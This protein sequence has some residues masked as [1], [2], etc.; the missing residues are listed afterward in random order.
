MSESRIEK[1][2][3]I[4]KRLLKEK[5]KEKAKKLIKIFLYIF[6]PIFTILLIIYFFIRVVGNM[7]LVVREYDVYKENLPKDFEGVKIVQFSDLHFNNNSSI[8][9][10][11]KMKELINK[12]NPDIVIFTG[13]L[14]DH[15]YSI[16]SDTLELLM[17]ELNG[18]N[19][20]YGKYAIKGEEDS[21]NFNIVFNNSNFKI[22][23]NSIERIYSG[24]SFIDLLAVDET[25][26]KENIKGYNDND[27]IISIIH[28]PDLAD[29]I[30]GD[31]NTGIILA[32]HS[33][34]G[35]IVLPL[36]G[37]LF[38]KEGAKKYYLPHYNIDATDLYISGGIGNSNHQ[39]RLFNH[40]SINFY[41]IRSISNK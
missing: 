24:S 12:A 28:K 34:N 14:I 23:D 26:S 31:F 3:S 9:T 10:V 6:V 27:F 37:P 19:A 18:I 20:K 30:I 21:E 7:G 32:G 16:D 11:K 39:W 5:N 35:Q 36:I 2:Q 1:N 4:T 15:F 25:Y 22:L 33:H 38:K 29:R 17:S 8:N 41:R 40:P 13:D